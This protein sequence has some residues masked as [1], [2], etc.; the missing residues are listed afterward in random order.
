MSD[1]PTGWTLLKN[2]RAFTKW[3]YAEGVLADDNPKTF[4]CLVWP[5][6]GDDNLVFVYRHDL[7]YFLAVLDGES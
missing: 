6:D 1:T 5:G 4:P 7:A 3:R 2:K